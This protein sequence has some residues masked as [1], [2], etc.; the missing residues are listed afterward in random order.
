MTRSRGFWNFM[1]KR[2][3]KSP[4]ED[5]AAYERK[6][7]LTRSHL[8]ADMEVLEF[9][10]GTGTTALIHAPYVAHIKAIDYSQKMIDIARG[11]A[12]ADGISNVSFDVATIEDLLAEDA[13]YDMIQAHSIL[14]LL[15]DLDAV[16]AKTRRLLKPGGR[17]ISSTVCTGEM[18]GFARAF[19]PLAG[20]LWILPYIAT[21]TADDLAAAITRAGFE[22]E[23]QW[24][25]REAG[26]IFIIAVVI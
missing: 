13:S 2:Y 10:C 25:P 6:L 24:R 11:K 16:L 19:L 18:S 14:H 1:A 17:F 3:A 8:S 5:Q 20:A 12:A 23:F 4:V 9:G 22:I 26:S 15:L 7:K 21:F